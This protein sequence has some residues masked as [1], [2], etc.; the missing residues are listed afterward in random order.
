ME[1]VTITISLPVQDIAMSAAFY[2]SLGFEILTVSP[3]QDYAV[4]A[5][6]DSVIGLY[7]GIITAPDAVI[8]S[9]WIPETA[10]LNILQEV[11]SIQ[12]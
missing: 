6:D 10:P 3:A 1:L 2:R 7:H 9:G 4:L 12:A 11:P 8:Q 5:S